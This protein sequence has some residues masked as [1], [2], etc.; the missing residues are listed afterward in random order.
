MIEPPKPSDAP[1]I[2]CLART[3]GVFTPEEV[4]VVHEMLDAFLHPAPG[5]DYSFV[6]YRNGNPNAID[7]FACFGPTPLTDRVW[8]LY[9]ICVDRAGQRQG[10]GTQ[11]LQGVE[12]ELRT[13]GARAVYLETSDSPQY[14]AARAFYQRHG[15]ECIAHINDFYA[16]GEGKV[17]YRKNLQ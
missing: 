6:V 17:M 3:V 12:N 14:C 11:L 1:A 5:D 16:P 9:W 7:G 10:I 2:E 13:R 8:D 15:Y 4:Q